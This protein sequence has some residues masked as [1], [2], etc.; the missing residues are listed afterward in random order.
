MSKRQKIAILGGGC[1]AVAAALGLTDTASRRAQ[2]EVTIYQMGWRLG[3]KGAAGRAMDKGARIEEH[4]FHIWLGF[5][6]HSF[7]M[8]RNVY[9]E[10]NRAP[11]EALATFEDAFTP[12]NYILLQE[13]LQGRW[14]HWPLPFP[15]NT[16]KP[17]DPG[18]PSLFDLFRQ[19]VRLL[20]MNLSDRQMW[21]QI[22]EHQ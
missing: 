20:A 12:H 8:I 13:Q 4:G 21:A 18:E 9:E 6:N 1:G 7:R 2:F 10:L 17:G 22:P 16:Q 19:G 5:Y 14:H 15:E 11:G 3:G